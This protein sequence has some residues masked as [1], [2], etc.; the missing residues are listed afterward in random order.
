MRNSQA[1][2]SYW[3]VFTI[4]ALAIGLLIGLWLIIHSKAATVDVK[5]QMLSAVPGTKGEDIPWGKEVNSNFP[6]Y[7]WYGQ[8][9]PLSNMDLTGNGGAYT[10]INW[11]GAIFRN[12]SN[13]NPDNTR[14]EIADCSLWIL[15]KNANSWQKLLGS[16][17]GGAT[18]PPDYMNG[19]PGESQVTNT[20]TGGIIRPGSNGI[21]HFWWGG[22]FVTIDPG[23]IKAAM[24]NCRARLVLA[25][26]SGPDDRSQ[27][28]YI[29]HMGADWRIAG[30]ENNCNP[31]PGL[32]VGKFYKIMNDWRNVT[33]QT[34]T[35]EEINGGTVMPPAEAFGE[36]GGTGPTPTVDPNLVKYDIAVNRVIDISDLAILIRDYPRPNQ[37][38][39]ANSPADFDK[40]GR[41][42]IID[43]SKLVSNWGKTY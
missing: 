12:E 4:M 22:G 34:L 19:S 18:F 9:Q 6:G 2:K 33:W 38:V 36:S 21:Y 13:A 20:A 28:G 14:V 8:A 23:N 1:A 35:Q 24:S 39:V 30:Q 42:D 25:N 3:N 41:V 31:C 37:P 5:A 27:S 16:E 10:R 17:F 15:F 43:L 32:G 26:P 29:V 7:D 40:N 11:W